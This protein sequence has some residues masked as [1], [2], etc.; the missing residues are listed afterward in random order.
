MPTV[1]I[2]SGVLYQSPGEH[3]RILESA[4]FEVRYPNPGGE[5]LT[6][7]QLIDN[8]VGVSATIAGSEPYTERVMAARPTL[9]VVARAGVGYDAVDLKGAKEHKVAVGITPGTNQDAVAE[10]AMALLLALTKSVVPFHQTVT[11]GRFVRAVTKPLWGTTLGLI[12]LGRIGRAMAIR[13]RAFGMKVLAFDPYLNATTWPTGDE[14]TFV[15]LPELLKQSDVISLHAPMTPETSKIVRSETIALMKDGVLILNTARGGLVDEADLSKAL[16]SGKV[17][18][19][20]LD[21]FANE[22]PVGS[23]LLDAERGLFPHIAGVSSDS[24]RRMAIMAAQTIV[25][26]HQGRWPSERLVNA[27]DLGPHWKWS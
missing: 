12:G 6:E 16:R 9:R 17:G 4:G 14:I 25:D 7:Q 5:Q 2:G 22:P 24:L 3:T 21:V 11:Q 19:A 8:L 23:P 10:Q 26:L 18:G 13:G 27:A 1:L 20:G 15:D